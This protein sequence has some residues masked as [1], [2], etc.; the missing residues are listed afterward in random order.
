MALV[1]FATEVCAR[2]PNASVPVVSIRHISTAYV[3]QGICSLRFG[4]GTAMGD[5]DAGNVELTL[6]FVDAKGKTLF[7]GDI[8]AD[9]QD[10]EAGRYQEVFLEDH[11]VCFDEPVRIQVVKAVA[12][13]EEG[14]FDLL[15]MDK[16]KVDDFKPYPIRIDR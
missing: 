15:K 9:L 7:E 8:G 10:S 16:L 3:N 13:N 6:R 14:T 11:G 1:L 12:Q 2:S 4:L 5:G